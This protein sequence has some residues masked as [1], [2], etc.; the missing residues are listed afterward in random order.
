MIVLLVLAVIAIGAL[1]WYLLG[2]KQKNEH[3]SQSKQRNG[4]AR[5]DEEAS[6]S[7]RR[8]KRLVERLEQLVKLNISIRERG[9]KADLC[10]K[11]E[12]FIDQL[13]QLLEELNT[14]FVGNVLTVDI[15][16]VAE[17]HFPR[18][19]TEYLDLSSEK[20][21]VER[22]A[23]LEALTTLEEIVREAENAVR[24]QDEAQ[25]AVASKLI[26]AKFGSTSI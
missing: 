17:K 14:N 12:N 20:Q 5:N 8:A 3:P 23:L 22:E 19:I 18:L 7:A 16:K 11:V 26:N 6:G 15:N 2:K 25:F 10:K 13:R 1:G 9:L 4:D 24:T 21:K